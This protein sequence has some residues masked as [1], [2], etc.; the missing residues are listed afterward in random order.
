M[1]HP[2]LGF[3]LPGGRARLEPLT[4]SHA[5]GLLDAID[6][7]DLWRY[8]PVA[9]PGTLGEME[10]VIAAAMEETGAGRGV[11]FAII[12]RR[13]GRACGSTRYLDPQPANRSIEI[14]W[15]WLSRAVQRT[16]INRECK[17][18]LL[19]HAFEVMGCVR[20]QL[21]CD[22]RNAQSQAAIA[23]LGAAREGVLRRHRVM[24]DG[25]IRDTVFFSILDDEWPRVAAGLLER[26]GRGAEAPSATG[27]RDR[28]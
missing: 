2:A 28:G 4:L 26:L 27:G 24:W 14:G 12:D 20:V 1:L 25:Y 15:T 19:R 6:A 18:L 17:Y 10:S 5:R 13:T 16:A 8:M 22:G 21:R 9:S 3:E 23:G 7:P 11:A